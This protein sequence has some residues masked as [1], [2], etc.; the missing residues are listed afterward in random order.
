MG[1]QNQSTVGGIPNPSESIVLGMMVT[2]TADGKVN[3]APAPN[4]PRAPTLDDVYSLA[5]R[6]KRDVEVNLTAQQVMRIQVQQVQQAAK[7]A[8]FAKQGESKQ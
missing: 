7:L 2:M 8:A 4:S 6:M 3:I 5:C 1:D